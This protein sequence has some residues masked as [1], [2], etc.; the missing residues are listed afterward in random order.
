MIPIRDNV[1]VRR[2][3]IVNW[4]LI[5]ANTWVFYRELAEGPGLERFIWRYGLVPLRY[6]KPG[7]LA[8]AGL[9][10]YLT[11]FFSSMFLHGGWMHII[12]N[13]WVLYIFGDNI[14]DRL[15]HLR[16]L[17]FYIACG[18]AA[19]FAQLWFSWGSPVPTLGASGAIAGVMGAFFILYP[20]ARVATLI[21][22]FIFFRVVEIPAAV[23]LALWLWSQV[24]SAS[25]TLSGAG[26]LGGVAWWAH[27]G[28]FLSGVVLLAFFVGPARRSR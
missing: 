4:L 7:L 5:A 6:A 23:F 22:I 8:K 16:Y 14:E 21:P 24:Y 27:I 18:L 12:S 2:T 10:G 3:P 28:G 17:F 20:F 25:L 15:G 13:M 9:V 11:P 19:A 1:P 26:S